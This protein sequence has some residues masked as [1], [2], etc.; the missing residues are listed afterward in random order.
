MLIAQ[1]QREDMWL[2]SNE[3]IFDA[4]GVRRYW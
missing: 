1:A 4:A 2:V 3:D